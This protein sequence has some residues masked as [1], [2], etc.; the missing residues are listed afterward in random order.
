[1]DSGI[2][3][4]SARL[5]TVSGDEHTRR[6]ATRK[7]REPT[8]SSSKTQKKSSLALPQN[9][10]RHIHTLA[11]ETRGFLPFRHIRFC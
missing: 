1:M 2:E 9:L 7:T 4:G 3:S 10:I 6:G 5:A 8:D 11:M